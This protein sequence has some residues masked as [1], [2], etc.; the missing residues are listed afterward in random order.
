MFYFLLFLNKGHTYSERY[1]RLGSRLSAL[2]NRGNP[3][4]RKKFKASE[5]YISLLSKGEI[6]GLNPINNPPFAPKT[7]RPGRRESF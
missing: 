3:T 7:N 5:I 1:T 6:L 2:A 4:K